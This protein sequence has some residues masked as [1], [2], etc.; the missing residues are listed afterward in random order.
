VVGGGCRAISVERDLELP[1]AERRKLE[2]RERKPH[3]DQVEGARRQVDLK[4][5]SDTAFDEGARKRE[6]DTAKLEQLPRLLL[7][8]CALELLIV[9][10]LQLRGEADSNPVLR[11]SNAD[12]HRAKAR[13]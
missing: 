6:P 9:F 8:P 11:L 7:E 12:S 10:E 13:G 4:A 2:P 1:D 3:V 5:A